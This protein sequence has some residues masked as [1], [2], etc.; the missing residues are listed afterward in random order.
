MRTSRGFLL[1]GLSGNMRIQTLPPRFI[2]R[3]IAR[4]AASICLA[5][6]CPREVALSPNSPKLTLLP[7]VA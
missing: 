3:L 7:L 6:I 1:I 2:A 4:R 5:V